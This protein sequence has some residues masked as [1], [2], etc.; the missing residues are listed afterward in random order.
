MRHTLF[1][2]LSDGRPV[3]VWPPAPRAAGDVPDPARA[4]LKVERGAALE[5]EEGHAHLRVALAV[6]ALRVV[7]AAAKVVANDPGDVAACKYKKR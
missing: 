4:P 5:R 3:E 2:P 7:L 1:V 6:H